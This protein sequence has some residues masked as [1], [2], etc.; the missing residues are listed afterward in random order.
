MPVDGNN[1]P[2]FYYIHKPKGSPAFEYKGVDPT[3]P[4]PRSVDFALMPQAESDHFRA[5][6]FGD[7][8]VNDETEMGYYE[9]DII[10][11]LRGVKDVAFGLSMG[12]MVQKELPQ[13]KRYAEITGEVGVPWYNVIG[14]HDLNHDCG[15][16]SL[17]HETFEATFGPVDYSFNYGRAH[18]IVLNDN[19]YPYPAI[20]RG[21]RPGLRNGLR[22]SQLEFIRNDLRY[23]DTGSLVV[24]AFHC[25]INIIGPGSI[26]DAVRRQYFE[27]LRAYPHVFNL[28]AHTHQ[29]DQNFYTGKDGWNG[30]QAY[31]ELDCG[32]TCG[33]WY[34]GMVNENGF[35]EGMMSN[36]TPRGYL[37]LNISGNRYTADYKVAG[38][39]ADYQIRLYH[40]KVLTPVWWDGRGLVYANFFMGYKDSKV[41]C[42]IDDGAWKPMK[43]SVEADPY[44]LAQNVRWDE[45]DTLFRGRRPTEAADCKHLWTAPLP[46]TLGV[47]TH[48]IEVRATDMFGRTYVQTSTY[49][50]ENPK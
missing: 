16:D 11:E 9:H 48:R 10:S 38:K 41:D 34:S 14:N 13:H 44:Y 4:L 37:Y 29:L 42:R 26:D 2:K 23:V 12:D 22:P 20:R 50:I 19:L 43:Y 6:V 7:P 46:C 36:G 24:L 18:F 21:Q 15:E 3:G 25:P 35:L 32:A 1:L 8:Q 47:G 5:L 33:N 45:A 49:R 28:C 27:I 39:P 31:H 30:V 40:R 17:N